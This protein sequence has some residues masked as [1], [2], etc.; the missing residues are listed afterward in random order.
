MKIESSVLLDAAIDNFLSKGCEKAVTVSFSMRYQHHISNSLGTHTYI[1]QEKTARQQPTE[2]V[3]SLSTCL[4]CLPRVHP[5]RRIGLGE[6][7][8]YEYLIS[9]DLQ[10]LQ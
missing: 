3:Y 7:S 1:F 10:R 2:A 8:C 6:G 5:I 9:Y 4:H